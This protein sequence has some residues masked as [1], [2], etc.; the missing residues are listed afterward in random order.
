MKNVKVSD[1]TVSQLQRLIR[2]T[3][4]QSVVE[5]LIEFSA[6][7]ELE[8]ESTLEAELVEYLRNK[9]TSPAYTGSAKRDD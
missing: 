9:N 3:V 7:R 4:Q 8:D 2:R 1:L 5:V 6:I